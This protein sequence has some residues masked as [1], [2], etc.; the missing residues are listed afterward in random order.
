M[1]FI[2]AGMFLISF[3]KIESL[4][5]DIKMELD[6]IK[7]KFQDIVSFKVQFYVCCWQ[8]MC[9]RIRVCV[10]V[11]VQSALWAIVDWSLALPKKSGIG[12]QKLTSTLK[13]CKW[14]RVLWTFPHKLCLWGQSYTPGIQ[15]GVRW[16]S[17]QCFPEFS[18]HW[19]FDFLCFSICFVLYLSLINQNTCYIWM[20]PFMY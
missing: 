2:F 20:V 8:R 16:K 12:V 10:C 3:Q 7:S 11:C 19:H 13:N 1:L 18:W 14:G 4:D 6:Y 5:S 15:V 17:Y 9:A